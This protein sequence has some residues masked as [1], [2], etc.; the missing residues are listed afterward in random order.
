MDKKAIM[1]KIIEKVGRDKAI[2]LVTQA[3]NTEM[4]TMLMARL[5]EK[6]KKMIERVI[7]RDQLQDALERVLAVCDLTA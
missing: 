5:E 4:L 7:M 1:K 2:E 3:Y 6:P